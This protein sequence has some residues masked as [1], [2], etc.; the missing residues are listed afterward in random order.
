V[1]RK[2]ITVVIMC[3]GRGK[4][5]GELTDELPKP[6]IKIN[7]LPIL[8]LKLNRYIEQ[9]I[10]IFVIC[11]GYKGELIRQFIKTLDLPKP[12]KIIFS[13][14]G[15]KSG[16]LKRFYDSKKYFTDNAIITYGDTLTELNLN[17]LVCN[18][19][20]SDNEATIV[21]GPIKNPFGL[22]EYNELNKVTYFKEKPT[23]IY[24]IGFALIQKS[25]FEL[26]SDKIINMNDGDGIVTFFKILMAMEKLGVYFYSGLQT[27][28]N[29]KEE[30][31]S[32]NNEITNFYTVME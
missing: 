14:S 20:C 23:L 1:K 32:A 12:I 27:T 17:D 22:V 28:F 8:Q 26:I 7:G 31:E 13:D 24:Y 19:K 29:T 16:I 15:L 21:V 25:A 30:L 9:G 4:R 18:H 2:K 10:N 11:I 5:M 6:L 3:G